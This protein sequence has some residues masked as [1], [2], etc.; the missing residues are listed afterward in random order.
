MTNHE[1]DRAALRDLVD[2]YARLADRRDPA[3]QA[4]LFTQDAR[5]TVFMGGTDAGEPAQVIEGRTTL[6]SEFGALRNYEQTTHF[7]GQSTVTVEGDGATG[8]TYCLA[9]HLW[10][11]DGGRVLMV[12]S[13]RYHDRF[14]RQDGRWLFAERQLLVD[15]VDRRPTTA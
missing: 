7:N 8:E 13:I 6:E 4:A 12:M 10:T 5:V 15:W 9:H 11:E 1:S 3:G 14:V 2:A